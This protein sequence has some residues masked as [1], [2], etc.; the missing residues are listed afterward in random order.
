MCLVYRELLSKIAQVVAFLI[1][2]REF[3]G[4]N[5]SRVSTILTDVPR[6]ECRDST[7]N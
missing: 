5:L 3:T 6:A 4:F 7:A 2:I 1:C